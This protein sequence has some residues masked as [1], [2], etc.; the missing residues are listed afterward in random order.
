MKHKVLDSGRSW[1]IN[2]TK[3][4]FL[5]EELNHPTLDAKLTC[6]L[7]YKPRSALPITTNI[8]SQVTGLY[9]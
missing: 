3:L 2:A 7:I 5:K 6:P 4:N 8:W 9:K 1:V